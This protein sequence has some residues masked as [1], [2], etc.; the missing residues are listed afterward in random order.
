MNIQLTKY[1]PLYKKFESLLV[2]EFFTVEQYLSIWKI[3]I[4]DRY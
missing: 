3:A 2:V 4:I 1:N